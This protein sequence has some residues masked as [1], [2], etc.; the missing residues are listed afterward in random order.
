VQQAIDYAVASGMTVEGDGSLDDDVIIRRFIDPSTGQTLFS[1]L[2]AQ[3]IPGFTAPPFTHPRYDM[4]S[5]FYKGIPF[6]FD[7]NGEFWGLKPPPVGGIPVYV[8]AEL[9]TAGAL[10]ILQ[11]TATWNARVPGSFADSVVV[12][13]PPQKSSGGNYIYFK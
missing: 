8:S 5:C 6:L 10:G 1:I 4:Q 7:K 11:A 2:S 12:G 13:I 9:G 3:Q